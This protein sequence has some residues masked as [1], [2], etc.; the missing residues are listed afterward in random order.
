MRCDHLILPE[1]KEIY[2][3]MLEELKKQLLELK[4]EED[5]FKT[6]SIRLFLVSF[7]DNL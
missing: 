2:A 4:D 5:C 6:L 1:N 7:I 3:S